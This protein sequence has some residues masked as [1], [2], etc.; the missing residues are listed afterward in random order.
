LA[1]TVKSGNTLSKSQ[2]DLKATFEKKFG[3]GSATAARIQRVAGKLH[4]VADKIGARGEGAS[5]VFGGPSAS[6]LATAIPGGSS[7]TIHDGFFGAAAKVQA[8]AIGHEGGHL[9]R[10]RDRGIRDA[11]MGTGMVS[12]GRPRAYGQE[13]TDWLGV[14]APG[15]ARNNTDSYMCL[16]LD[17][18]Q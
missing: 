10:L 4:S 14:N 2:A 12:M 11:P 17:C 9:A 3:S 16:A 13:A 7:M 18:Y 1:E 8:Y 6:A 15:R 5:V